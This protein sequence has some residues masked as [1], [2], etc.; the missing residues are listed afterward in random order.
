MSEGSGVVERSW[1]SGG[2]GVD[3]SS[4]SITV[5]SIGGGRDF[6]RKRRLS[7]AGVPAGRPTNLRADVEAPVGLRAATDVT[8]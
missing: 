5:P 2:V 3:R 6:F 1:I 7:R 4:S 8:E